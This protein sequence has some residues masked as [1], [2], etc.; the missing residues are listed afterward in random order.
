MLILSYKILTV[1]WP[2]LLEI[3]SLF[4]E[5]AKTDKYLTQQFI[6]IL[7]IDITLTYQY[8]QVFKFIE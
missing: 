2:K 7:I 3:L 1:I 4:T 8:E 5:I 6:Q